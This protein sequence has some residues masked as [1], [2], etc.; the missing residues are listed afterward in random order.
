MKPSGAACFRRGGFK[1]NWEA[2]KR[3]L[4]IQLLLLLVFNLGIRNSKYVLKTHYVV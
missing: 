3:H 1:E 2:I 4:S